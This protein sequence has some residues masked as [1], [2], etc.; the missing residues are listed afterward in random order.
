LTL[1]AYVN[2]IE[3]GNLFIFSAP[4]GCGK[5]TLVRLLCENDSQ[6]ILSISTTTRPRRPH[7]RHTKDYFFVSESE[8]SEMAEEERFLESATVFGHLYGTNRDFVESVLRDGNDVIFDIDW[9]GARQLKSQYEGAYSF[10]LIPPSMDA[11]RKRLVKREQD[12]L[13]TIEYRMAKARSEITHFDEF[14]F[15]VVNDSI[16]TLHELVASSIDAIRHSKPVYLPDPQPVIN[17]LLSES[18]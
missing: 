9:Q 13:K 15:V 11:L 1:V 10:F 7:E 17:S 14:D 18:V 5:S 2:S 4:S 16:S 3:M 8:F 12:D 6:L